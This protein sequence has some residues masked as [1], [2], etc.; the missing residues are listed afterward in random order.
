M[1]SF[2]FQVLF[3]F[4]CIGPTFAVA[5]EQSMPG[6]STRQQ[7]FIQVSPM[8]VGKP[9][10]I[11]TMGGNGSVYYINSLSNIEQYAMNVEFTIKNIGNVATGPA[12]STFS[13][14]AGYTLLCQ[15]P[16]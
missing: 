3:I 13:V 15:A 2:L 11:I 16:N 12:G 1:V 4:L 5:A 10:L 9:D 8:P 7:P 6:T 14:G